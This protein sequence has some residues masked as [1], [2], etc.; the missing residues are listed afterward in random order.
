[1]H[2]LEA[3]YTNLMHHLVYFFPKVRNIGLDFMIKDKT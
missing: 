1:M 2:I 3:N